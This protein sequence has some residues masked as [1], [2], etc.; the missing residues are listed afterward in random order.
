MGWL[1]WAPNVAM[2]S[3]VNNILVAVEGMLEMKYP[4]AKKE[5]VAS[6]TALRFKDFARTH[7]AELKAKH[8]G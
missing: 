3:N 7:N 1:G 8:R 6:A 5:N 4:E 2:A